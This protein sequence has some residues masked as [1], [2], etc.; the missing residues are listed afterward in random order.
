MSRRRIFRAAGVERRNPDVL[1]PRARQFFN[2]L[3]HLLRR[4]VGEGDRHNRP[5]RHTVLQQVRHAVRQ[6]AGLAR[7]RACSTAS[8]PS[9]VSLRAVLCSGRF[10]FMDFLAYFIAEF[11]FAQNELISAPRAVG[12]A[13]PL[14]RL[15][16]AV[17]APV[18][19]AISPDRV[20]F[21]AKG[22]R[23]PVGATACNS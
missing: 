11:R 19:S 14:T 20:T 1:L 18:R 7:S 2:A 16:S 13:A 9:S 5:R 4:L 12:Q 17:L 8:G 21:S 15:M 6:R 3:P 10:K 22:A 23:S